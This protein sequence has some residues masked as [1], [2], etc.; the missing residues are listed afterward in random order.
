MNLNL[1]VEYQDLLSPRE[2]IVLHA[3]TGRHIL[4]VFTFDYA[5]EHGVWQVM[6]SNEFIH[7]L[8][9]RDGQ[10]SEFFPGQQCSIE[11]PIMIRR[12][13]REEVVITVTPVSMFS[14]QQS[15]PA[16]N[17]TAEQRVRGFVVFLLRSL[18][19]LL[20]SLKREVYNDLRTSDPSK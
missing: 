7:I 14:T 17:L 9:Q 4:D 6:H 10:W 8:I 20:V 5:C 11:H 15:H 19:S 18:I 1:A 16:R 2:E 13:G 12:G 3:D